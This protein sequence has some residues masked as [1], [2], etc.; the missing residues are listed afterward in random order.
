[1]DWMVVY[2]DY[3][4]KKKFEYWGFETKLAAQ[5]YAD[6]IADQMPYTWA[7]KED[8]YIAYERVKTENKPFAFITVMA[9]PENRN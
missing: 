8:G 1:M 9:T 6:T 2:L 5:R 3:R 4:H 7:I